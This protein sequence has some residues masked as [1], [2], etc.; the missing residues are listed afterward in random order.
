M[1]DTD[2]E[3]C[4]AVCDYLENPEKLKKMSLQIAE[5]FGGCASENIYNY[6]CKDVDCLYG[7][8]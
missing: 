5:E 2:I 6:V 8:L 1:R 3:L 7:R 4:D